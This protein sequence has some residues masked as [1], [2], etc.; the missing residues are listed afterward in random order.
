MSNV[1][2]FVLD[3]EEFLM[4]SIGKYGRRIPEPFRIIGLPGNI[5]KRKLCVDKRV[6]L[7]FAPSDLIVRIHLC[8]DNYNKFMLCDK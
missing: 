3:E 7:Q 1:F 2:E 4:L 6:L 8:S 5:K